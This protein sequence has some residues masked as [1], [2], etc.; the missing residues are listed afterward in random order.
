MKKRIYNTRAA[1]AKDKTIILFLTILVF[2]V[3]LVCND[4]GLGE[5]NMKKHSTSDINVAFIKMVSTCN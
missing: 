1:Y 4:F 5:K 2:C 3:A